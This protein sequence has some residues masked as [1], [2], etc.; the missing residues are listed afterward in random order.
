MAGPVEQLYNCTK[1]LHS[2]LSKG[3][4]ETDREEYIER[5]E[6]LLEERQQWIVEYSASSEGGNRTGH[7][8]AEYEQEIQKMIGDMFEQIREDVHRLRRQKTTSQRYAN[9]YRG[10]SADGMFLDK[11]K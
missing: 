4:P 3:L 2:H 9:P 11:R 1:K 7:D 5:I 8:I 10:G 6:S